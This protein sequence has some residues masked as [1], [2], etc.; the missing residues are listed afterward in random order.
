MKPDNFYNT[1][2]L[3]LQLNTMYKKMEPLAAAEGTYK[4]LDITFSNERLQNIEGAYCYSDKNG[5]HYCY[6][7][8]GKINTHRITKNFFELSYWVIKGQAFR[9]ALDYEL[10]HRIKGKDPRRLIF[11][12]ELQL[13]ELVGIFYKEKA[14]DEIKNILSK[15]PYQDQLFL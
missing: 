3:G 11:E 4:P 7:E 9:M 10:K 13:L 15:A 8:R 6:V 5:C 14:E 2:E 12:K 1:S